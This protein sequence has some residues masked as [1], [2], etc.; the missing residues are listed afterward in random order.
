[1]MK[2][3]PTPT[4]VP[5]FLSSSHTS[6]IGLQCGSRSRSTTTKVSFLMPFLFLVSP[7]F[8][9]SRR[10]SC[11]ITVNLPVLMESVCQRTSFFLAVR[12]LCSRGSS[13]AECTSIGIR[14]GLPPR[15]ILWVLNSHGIQKTFVH[16]R[17]SSLPP[18]VVLLSLKNSLCGGQDPLETF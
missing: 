15:T 7:R 14:H 1:M 4:S 8:L 2:H 9:F 3:L 12:H 10:S 17:L 5:H 16:L 18:C 13:C 11:I 6:T